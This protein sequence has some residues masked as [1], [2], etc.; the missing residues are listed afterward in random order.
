MLLFCSTIVAAGGQQPGPA[1]M[2]GWHSDSQGS[3]NWGDKET[4]AS[5]VLT[6]PHQQG[7]ISRETE[8][9]Q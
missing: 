6:I 8:G 4:R 1:C 3:C 2:L 5:E 9:T 7:S